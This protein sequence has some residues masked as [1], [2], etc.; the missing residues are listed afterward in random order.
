MS[1]K[2]CLQWNDFQENAKAAFGILRYDKNFT[3]VTLACEDGEQVEAHRVI[4]ASSSPFFQKL[5]ER[6]KHPH[7]LVYMKGLNSEN[8]LAMIDFLYC[9][10][11]NVNQENLDSF[12]ALAEELQLKGL[13]GKGDEKEEDPVYEGPEHKMTKPKT[14]P[15]LKNVASSPK[16]LQSRQNTLLAETT[17]TVALSTH[18]SG[19]LEDLEQR[20]RS[21]MEK[22]QNDYATGHQKA[23]KCKVCGKEGKGNAIKDHIEAHH[24]EGI[25]LPCDQCEKTFR[26]RNSFSKHRRTDHH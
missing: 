17:N 19:N 22:S 10:E 20:V 6:T 16:T 12:L 15:P 23:H 24:L 26:C 8:L 3:D 14:N 11:A 2:L 9:G 25:V 4:L 13:M 18:F 1:D 7:P 5:L 21:M